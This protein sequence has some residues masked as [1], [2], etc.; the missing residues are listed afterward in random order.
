MKKNVFFIAVLVMIMSCNMATKK[1]NSFSITD[2]SKNEY[3]SFGEGVSASEILYHNNMM[4]TYQNLKEGDTVNI[5]FSG[6]VN[7]VCQVKGCWMKI[8]LTKEKEAM[9]KFKDYGFFMPKDIKNDTV[10]VQG[11][12]FVNEV[13]VEEQKHY[14][15]DA[16]KTEEE[17]AAI[18]SPK[19]T[20]SFI[21]DGVLIKE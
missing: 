4:D 16:G 21:A 8:A 14:A 11:K 18:V 3:K 9:I 19:K 5:A 20:Y 1:Q 10:I 15:K 12:A 13:S 7:N 6:T 17:I 2:T